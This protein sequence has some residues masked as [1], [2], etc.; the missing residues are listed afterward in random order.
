ML[1]SACIGVVMLGMAFAGNC[2]DQW[3]ISMVIR[4]E[5]KSRGASLCG[6]LYEPMAY[7]PLCGRVTFRRSASS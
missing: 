3:K 4:I 1:V 2:E 7:N 5:V 6:I